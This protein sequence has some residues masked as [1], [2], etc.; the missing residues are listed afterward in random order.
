[1]SWRR[2]KFPLDWALRARFSDGF[3]AVVVEEF[4]RW[5]IDKPWGRPYAD[6]M[7]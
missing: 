3:E 6:T 2:V 4:S 7:C 1:M 5:W